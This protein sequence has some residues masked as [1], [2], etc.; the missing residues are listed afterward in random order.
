MVAA[1]FAVHPLHVESVAWIAERKDLL[2]TFFGL[3]ALLAYVRY[4]TAHKMQTSVPGESSVNAEKWSYAC[5]LVFFMLGLL[6]KPMLVT[7]PFVMLL[8]DF[9]PLERMPNLSK[10]QKLILEKWPF[11]GLT[12]TFCVIT[13][14]AQKSA[15]AT[16]ATAHSPGFQ[17]ANAL[18]S[19]IEYIGRTFWPAK[20]AVIYPF[21]PIS[22]GLA[23][24]AGIV[25]L[26]I[27]ISFLLAAKQKP[28]LLMGWLWYLGTLVPVIGLVQVGDQSSAD[29]YTYIPIIGL[30][31]IFVWG[32]AET[33]A[34]WRFPKQTAGLAGAV[35]LL[36]CAVD[37]AYQLQFWRNGVTLFDR[38]LAVTTDNA[39][40]QNDYATALAAAGDVHDAFPHYAEA[41][42]L[43][44]NDAVMQNNYGVALMRDGQTNAAI[45]QYEQAIRLQTNYPD[46][47]SNLGTVLAT[48][49]HFDEAIAL[50]NHAVSLQPDNVDLHD[51][52]AA[53]L[54]MQGKPDDAVA[55]YREAIRLNPDNA[56]LHLNFGL[57][58][59]RLGAV[60]DATQE[61]SEAL[62]IDPES[63]E[64]QFQSGRCL[65]ILRQ[66]DQA[67]FHLQE[68]IRLQ[69]DWTGPLNALAW[70][71]ATDGNAQI[72]N[73][74]K[75]VS[76]AEHA[77]TLSHGLDPVI[78]NTLAAAYAEAGRFEEAS[79]MANRAIALAQQTGQNTLANQIQSLLALYR[80]HRAFHHS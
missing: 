13:W 35:I 66:P 22:I 9:W 4:A 8:L 31:I 56:S 6:S 61:F 39:L 79:N 70:I 63:P 48:E 29:R 23:A 50:L 68:A 42:R 78:L 75:A 76:L 25:L 17:V 59:F 3:L 38:A 62:R 52:L 69:P 12:V 73:G 24:G 36:A 37:T 41:A 58:L 51:N 20:L 71:F 53:A 60:P 1:L 11:F 74:P 46:A 33:M 10:T 28:Y 34:R 43:A 64:A 57:A 27:S 65:A 2:C 44:P 5:A 18:V 55:Q 7:L 67:I 16:T 19:Y 77:A 15:G 21:S 45:A 30:F 47:Y 72:R 32:A 14:A 80:Q 49:G 40:A 54:L 26:V